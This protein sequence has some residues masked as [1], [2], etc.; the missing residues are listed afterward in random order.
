MLE[1]LFQCPNTGWR[2]T[3]LQFYLA[4]G[5]NEKQTSPN[6]LEFDSVYSL[7]KILKFKF[8]SSQDYFGNI[9]INIYSFNFLSLKLTANILI[10]NTTSGV[11]STRG[12]HKGAPGNPVKFIADLSTMTH[13]SSEKLE[14]HFGTPLSRFFICKREEKG[15]GGI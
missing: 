7:H 8:F 6:Q 3:C 14:V 1:C 11:P 4:H 12:N 9:I 5:L 2:D 13:Q 15:E 10:F